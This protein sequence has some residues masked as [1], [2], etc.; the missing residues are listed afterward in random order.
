[1]PSYAPQVPV[2]DRWAI[3]AYVRALQYSQ[4]ARLADLAQAG[5]PAERMR[6]IEDDLAGTSPDPRKVPE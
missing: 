6:Q 5:V 1:M 2:N 3:A 4:N